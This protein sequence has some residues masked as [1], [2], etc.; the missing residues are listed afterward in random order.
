MI[1]QSCLTTTYVTNLASYSLRKQLQI[2]LSPSLYN[3]EH[4]SFF[5][6]ISRKKES[7]SKG[8][9]LFP[10]IALCFLL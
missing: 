4:P 6:Q 10:Q 2:L 5:L 9:K 3:D 7:I 1:I 8:H